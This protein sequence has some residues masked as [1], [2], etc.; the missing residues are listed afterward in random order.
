MAAFQVITIGRFWVITEAIDTIRFFHLR[1]GFLC[2]LGTAASGIGRN[3]SSGKRPFQHDRL[4]SSHEDEQETKEQVPNHVEVVEPV[5]VNINGIH[6]D[7]RDLY[8][9]GFLFGAPCYVASFFLVISGFDRIMNGARL[10]GWSV[11]M[12][13]LIVACVGIL[14]PLLGPPWT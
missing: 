2:G 1:D 14:S 10:K 4:I 9:Y 6:R 3:R 11:L 5:L 12:L 8:F 13:A 7:R